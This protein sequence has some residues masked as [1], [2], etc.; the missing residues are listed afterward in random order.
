MEKHE[1]KELIG[2]TDAIKGVSFASL[3][4]TNKNNETSQYI[5]NLGIPH[6]RV[7]KRDLQ[8]LNAKR[9]SLIPVMAE[10]FGSDLVTKAYDEMTASIVSSLNGTNAR[11]QAQIDAYVK[12]NDSVKLCIESRNL[13]L[14]GY[15]V[16]KKVLEYG[17]YPE[18]KKQKKTIVKDAI[19]KELK[20]KAGKYRTFIFDSTDTF[21][22]G[23]N[24]LVIAKPGLMDRAIE[25]T[26]RLV[27]RAWN[28][29]K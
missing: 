12:V 19:C 3:V 8:T 21:C 23:G 26:K 9:E 24:R 10:K 18:V 22:T 17:E 1:V 29:F 4:Y 20:L 15:L 28:L 27:S 7:L 2:M 16:S 6:H 11:A 14:Y 13:T 5:I 25:W